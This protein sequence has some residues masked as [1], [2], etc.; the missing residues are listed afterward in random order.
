METASALVGLVVALAALGFWKA[1]TGASD[2]DVTGPEPRSDGD[3]PDGQRLDYFRRAPEPGAGAV[4]C[5]ICG[6]DKGDGHSH[7]ST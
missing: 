5:W 2:M 7:R 3:T 4:P 6:R 1:H